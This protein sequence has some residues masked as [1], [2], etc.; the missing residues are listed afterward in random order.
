MHTYFPKHLTVRRVLESAW[1]D[2][3]ISKPRLGYLEDGKVDACLRWFRAELCPDQEDTLDQRAET[4]YSTRRRPT[5]KDES[6]GRYLEI[7]KTTLR[8][9][10][11]LLNPA[12]DWADKVRFGELTFSAQRVAL[13][14]RAIIKSPDLV[15]LDEA[16]SGMDELARDKCMLFLNHGETMILRHVHRE[17]PRIRRAGAS[18]HQSALDQLR[19][20]RVRGLSPDQALVVVAHSRDEVP[21]C[22]REYITLPESGTGKKTPLIGRIDG[23]LSVDYRRWGEIWGMPQG[24][25]RPKKVSDEEQRTRD[26]LYGPYSPLEVYSKSLNVL[27]GA[28]G[29]P[30]C[31]KAAITRWENARKL[32]NEEQLKADD[33]RIKKRKAPKLK[34][35]R[36][37]TRGVKGEDGKVAEEK[38]AEEK[39]AEE[40]PDE[41]EVD[42]EDK[43]KTVKKTDKKEEDAEE[44]K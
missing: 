38:V 23:P 43:K 2:T 39:V 32:M 22:V 42:E 41:E 40:T 16:F 26:A 10:E 19:R 12:I 33:E 3:P 11:A 5:T 36:P 34:I 29:V 7:T 17:K 37:R 30:G 20:V 6:A 1:A 44:K 28:M 4:Y 21:G 14:L 9:E 24:S 13:F 31:G 18:A 25:G 8:D 27:T 15:V 35:G